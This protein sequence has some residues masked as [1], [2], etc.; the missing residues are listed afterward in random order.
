[1]PCFEGDSVLNTELAARQPLSFADR[2]AL[3]AAQA[4]VRWANFLN[5]EHQELIVL[6]TT[7]VKRK[8]N[9]EC[10]PIGL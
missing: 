6:A 8:G 9:W 4:H 10:S 5:P 2:K 1:M 3:A 7:V